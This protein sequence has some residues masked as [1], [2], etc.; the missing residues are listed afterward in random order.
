[1]FDGCTFRLNAGTPERGCI[2]GALH[3]QPFERGGNGGTG[4]LHTSIINNFMIYQ[5]HFETNS[6]QLFAHTK[7]SGWFSI[8]SAN[9]FEVNIV[10]KHVNP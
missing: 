5:D 6:L 8:I 1:V 9:S 10:G 4:A 2:T 3:P 7:N